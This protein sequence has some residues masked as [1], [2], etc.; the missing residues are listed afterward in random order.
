MPEPWPGVDE[1]CG[2]YEELASAGEVVPEGVVPVPVPL[3]VPL[4]GA[5]PQPVTGLFPGNALNT[6]ASAMVKSSGTAAGIL[7]EVL[8]SFKP[9]ISPGHLSIPA[10]PALQLSMICCR[11][12]GT[13]PEI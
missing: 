8:G 12:P 6:V 5:E 2:A 1:P 10:S 11:V 7:Q 3:P 13:H 9:P 4:P